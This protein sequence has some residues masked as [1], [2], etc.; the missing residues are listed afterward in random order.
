M[1]PRADPGLTLAR[2]EWP[3]TE[4][5]RGQGPAGLTQPLRA[6]AKGQ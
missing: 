5:A 4:L 1:W 6:R 3:R 2:T